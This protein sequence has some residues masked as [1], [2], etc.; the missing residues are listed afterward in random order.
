MQRQNDGKDDLIHGRASVECAA[1]PPSAAS[2]TVGAKIEAVALPDSWTLVQ[3]RRKPAWRRW[4]GGQ[5]SLPWL[6]G[7]AD[8]ATE[9]LHAEAHRRPEA[10]NPFARGRVPRRSGPVRAQTQHR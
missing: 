4:L 9:T 5:Q 1:L 3:R 10:I 7:Q 8:P 2:V 6:D